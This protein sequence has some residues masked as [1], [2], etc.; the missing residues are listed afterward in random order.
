M[1]FTHFL[2][3]LHIDN[4]DTLIFHRKHYDFPIKN[5]IFYMICSSFL[6]HLCTENK[7][8]D[9]FALKKHEFGMKNELFLHIFFGPFTYR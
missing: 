1:I 5:D 2:I 8:N 7:E 3:H 9:D 4:G 6:Q